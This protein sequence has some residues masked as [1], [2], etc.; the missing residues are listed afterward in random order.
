MPK[1]GWKWRKEQLRAMSTSQLMLCLEPSRKHG[2]SAKTARWV[3]ENLCEGEDKAGIRVTAL[4]AMARDDR[5]PWVAHYLWKQLDLHKAQEFGDWVIIALNRSPQINSLNVER[6]I[7]IYEDESAHDSTRSSAIF[8]LANAAQNAQWAER[9]KGRGMH[10][11]PDTVWAR[12]HSTCKKAVDD[13]KRPYARAGA[14][15][16]ATILGGY[17]AELAILAEDKTP[18]YDGSQSPTVSDYAK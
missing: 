13:H 5:A 15:W 6:L 18:V 8:A 12:I 17:D 10:Q 7:D 3:Y 14:A 11:L 2:A 16:L 9:W 4:L 1:H